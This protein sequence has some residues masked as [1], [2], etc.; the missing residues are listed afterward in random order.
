MSIIPNIYKSSI[1]I[2]KYKTTSHTHQLEI[3]F[4][5]KQYLHF[6]IEH[7]YPDKC[8]IHTPSHKP[9]KNV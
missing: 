8:L 2:I 4:P 5:P 1:F 6:E 7:R 3:F 9:T